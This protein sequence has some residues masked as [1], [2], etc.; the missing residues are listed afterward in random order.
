MNL[1]DSSGWLEYFADGP[2]ASFFARPL[3]DLSRVVVPA[4][5]LLEVFKRILQQR[6][7]DAALQA[8]S[9]IQQ[10]HVI[11]LDT[12]LALNAAKLG[13]ILK[14]PLADSVILA[15][16]RKYEATIWTQDEHFKGIAR[17]RYARRSAV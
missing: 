4:I 7:E 2:N 17:V 3:E 12:E 1:V 5:C 16:A 6:S 10:G 13:H 8:V 15:M 14:L 11:P 9:V